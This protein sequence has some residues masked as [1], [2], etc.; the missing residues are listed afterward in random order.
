MTDTDMMK[1]GRHIV[2]FSLA[3]AAVALLSSCGRDGMPEGGSLVSFVLES[4]DGGPMDIETKT[5]ETNAATLTSFDV[6]AVTG[7]P[8]SESPGWGPVS[9]TGTT[10]YTGGRHWP[11]EGDPE[12][13][14]YAS[15]APM[16]FSAAG[17]TVTATSGTD[18]VVA[19]NATATPRVR[20]TLTFDHIFSRIGY[21]IVI[22]EAGYTVSDVSVSITPK[23]GGVYNIRTGAWSSVTTGSPTGIAPSS[24]GYVLNDVYLVPGEYTLT[25]S[26]HVEKGV[27]S[28]DFTGVESTV[29]LEAGHLHMMEITLGGNASS[30]IVS[31]SLNPWSS[32]SLD[33]ETGEYMTNI[34]VIPA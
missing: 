22:Q 7:T 33:F 9:F 16:A 21:V 19:R 10:V 5:V 34:N 1:T 14:F 25:A 27:Y 26:W 12:W 15:N 29:T 23:T 32:L 31:L 18:V 28:E 6:L 4:P 11:L 17:A 13:T 20:N 30:I 24:P 3:F 8:G 2:V